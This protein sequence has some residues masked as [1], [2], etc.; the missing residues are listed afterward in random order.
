MAL[1]DESMKIAQGMT[2]DNLDYFFNGMDTPEQAEAEE[3]AKP[4]ASDTTP[5]ARQKKVSRAKQSPTEKS[6]YTHIRLTDAVKTDV[7]RSLQAYRLVTGKSVSLSEF[8]GTCV[9][10]ALPHISKEA[11]EMVRLIQKE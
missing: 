9:R 8:I 1:K 3:P 6:K 2:P 10:R 5:N 11:A 7:D 4:N